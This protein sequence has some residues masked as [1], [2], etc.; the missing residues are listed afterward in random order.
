MKN[1]EGLERFAGY[2]SFWYVASPYSQYSGGRHA[3]FIEAAHFTADLMR[4]GVHPFSPICHTH[5]VSQ[6]GALQGDHEFWL[7]IDK[8]MLDQAAGLIVYMMDGWRESRGVSEEIEMATEW[9]LPIYYV[10]PESYRVFAE[11]PEM[12]PHGV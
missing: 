11:A 9:N 10:A 3:A 7:N 2:G 8:T 4:A 1:I 6:Y 12:V 5:P